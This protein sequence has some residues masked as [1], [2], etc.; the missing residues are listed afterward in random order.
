MRSINR[1]RLL[2]S[3]V[4]CGAALTASCAFADQVPGSQTEE[5]VRRP[6]QPSKP[7]P[8]DLVRVTP[9]G[10]VDAAPPVMNDPGVSIA[11]SQF[12]F[13]GNASVPAESLAP[14]LRSY[15]GKSLTLAELNDAAGAVRS[16]YRGRG[17]FL[18]QAYIPAQVP[19]DGVVE[20]AV[21][22]GRIDKLTINV[23]PDAPID[24]GYANRLA[25]AF[26]HSGQTITE[27]GLERPLLL[28][29]DLPRIDAKSVIDPGSVP[30]TANITVNLVRDPDLRIFSG[31]VDVD[32]YGSR[33]TGPTRVGAELSVNNPFGLG[34]SLSLR[35]FVANRSGNSF[36]RAGYTL[37]VGARGARFGV[38]VARLD[39]VLGDAFA[40]LKP[41]G[42][43][44]VL[45]ANIDYPVL[46]GRNTNLYA[47]LMVERKN[48]EDR[49]AAPFTS[50]KH[51]LNSARF[52]LSGDVRDDYAGVTVYSVSATGGKLHEQ[53]P[54]RVKNDELK[55]EG[56]FGKAL[57]SVQRLQQLL[58]GVHAMLSV[59]GQYANKN[60]TSA[61][62]FSI[63]GDSTVRAFPVGALVG[64]QGYTATAELRWTPAALKFNRI[65]MAGVMFYD[66]GRA[67]RNHDNSREL[68]PVN[69]STI[70]GYGVGFNLGFA[71]S[72]L[73]KVALARPAK[74]LEQFDPASQAMITEPKSSRAWV[75]ATYAF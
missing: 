31:H 4:G 49:T 22:E 1:A 2:L 23:A 54:E 33:A 13:S 61:E 69:T 37:A 19:T 64:D 5:P 46:R 53:D 72:F 56:S 30:G 7:A 40:F 50:D 32:N 10:P 29:R 47:Q 24:A 6:A 59:S 18:A 15:L 48:L 51:T 74:G 60:L 66:V 43:A 26:L 17:W 58:P 14:L 63:G 3:A 52:Q 67:T 73:F 41:N 27:T 68:N 42:I 28:L 36:G 25:Q 9:A 55:T 38:N 35:G 34:D 39:Y 8:Q 45:S 21:L 12:R 11:V 20:I 65:E 16:Y 62:K 71:N 75:L 70:G 44:N 57:F